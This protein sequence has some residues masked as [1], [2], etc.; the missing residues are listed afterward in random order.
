MANKVFLT[1][2]S[3]L[4]FLLPF[5]LG[6]KMSDGI[7]EER[8]PVARLYQ[9]RRGTQPNSNWHRYTK[10]LKKRTERL[11]RMSRKRGARP[12][13]RERGLTRPWDGSE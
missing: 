5:L 8:S 7:S 3:R 13:M 9:V 4:F 2:V 10:D 6:R 12:G 1:L 11:E